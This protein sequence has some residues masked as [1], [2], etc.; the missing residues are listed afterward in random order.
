MGNKE[1]LNSIDVSMFDENEVVR[2]L[3]KVIELSNGKASLLNKKLEEYSL[4]QKKLEEENSSLKSQI[5]SMTEKE[6]EA[7]Q[8]KD[9]LNNDLA[10]AN[11]KMATQESTI[12]ELT[13]KTESLNSELSAANVL[14]QKKEESISNIREDNERLQSELST[15][16]ALLESQNVKIQGLT[17]SNNKLNDSLSQARIII[18]ENKIGGVKIYANI[19]SY[20]LSSCKC[21]NSYWDKY[22][23]DLCQKIGKFIEET[24]N[25]E[26]LSFSLK[27]S[28]SWLTKIASI[29]WWSKQP[30]VSSIVNENIPYINE[31]NKVFGNLIQFL[32]NIDIMIQLPNCDFCD[33]I[34][35]Y[36][37]NLKARSNF[38]DLFG[39]SE[40]SEGTL[41]EIYK[42]AI[43][44]NKGLCLIYNS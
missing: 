41:C 1:M 28:N 14:V 29:M 27:S 36:E 38:N 3:L 32:I 24:T 5:K 10:L 20:L 40:I 18:D 33:M 2:L 8:L 16:T 9:Q 21:E 39:N 12:E 11:T 22:L 4:A 19:F 7:T 30:T 26:I 23:E 15:K 31:L 37:A 44:G 25:M 6:V 43:N 34:D 35:N 17:D 42:L 13:A